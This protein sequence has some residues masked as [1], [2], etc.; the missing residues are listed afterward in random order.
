MAPVLLDIAVSQRSL[1]LCR[2]LSGCRDQKVLL[3]EWIDLLKLVR[4]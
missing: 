4:I 3:N 1:V 2:E